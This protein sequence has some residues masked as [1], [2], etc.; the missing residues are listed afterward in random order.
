MVTTLPRT[1][2]ARARATAGDV[3]VCTLTDHGLARVLG[4]H[5]RVAIAGP[6][7]TANLGIERLVLAVAAAPQVGCLIICGTDSPI[8]RQGQT[9]LALARNGRDQDGRVI[10][11]TGHQPYL[12]NLRPAVV[13][14]FRRR[15]NVIDLIGRTDRRALRAVLDSLPS[16]MPASAGDGIAA[17]LRASGP[18][19][20]SLPAG[21]RR[22]PVARSNRGFFVVSVDRALGDLVL[23]HYEP[24]MATCHELRSH[25]AEALLLGAIGHGL[26]GSAELSHAGYLG[27]ELAKAETA[28]RLGLDYVQDRPLNRAEDE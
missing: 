12:R 21:G 28:L 8:F 10:G 18:T 1:A 26:L 19:V 7:A 23:R 13:E 3:A 16:G 17:A 5:E 14:E 25:N 6:L 27:G 9:L 11:A 22:C 20:I 15:V 24:D 4:R 2:T